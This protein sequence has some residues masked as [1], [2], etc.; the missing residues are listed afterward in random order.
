MRFPWSVYDELPVSKRNTAQIFIT[1]QCNLNCAGCFAKN[2]SLL[3]SSEHMDF[4]EYQSCVTHAVQK[5]AQQIN[6]L[7]GEPY[8]H[9]LLSEMLRFNR[10]LELKTTVYTN[11]TML[12]TL[13]KTDLYG[14]KLRVSIYKFGHGTKGALHLL[15]RDP[16][17]IEFD[18]NFMVGASTT[19]EELLETAK[20][21]ENSTCCSVFFI[22]SIRECDNDRDFFEDTELTMSVIQYK[23]L[24]H[25]FL[26]E[27]NGQMEIHI[28]KRGVFEST[29]SI[30]HNRCKF[31]NYSPGNR[32]IQCPYDVSNLRFQEEYDFN[33][34]YCRQN[35]TCLMSKIVVQRRGAKDA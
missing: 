13:S 4:E 24:V 10:M 3:G 32:I 1:S 22:S 6:L 27:Y 15:D 9:P 18:A 2:V 20:L 28:S 11:G 19:V 23:E 33:Q 26:H 8:L 35:N 25:Q 17:D 7:G 5:G 21:G 34:R 29:K 12:D 30:P 31:V 14:A 16:G